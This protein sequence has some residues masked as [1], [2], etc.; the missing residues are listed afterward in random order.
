MILSID[1]WTIGKTV[2]WSAFVKKIISIYSTHPCCGIWLQ[3]SPVHCLFFGLVVDITTLL[4]TM[5]HV[6]PLKR[7]LLQ[8]IN[9][10]SS[11]TKPN[12]KFNWCIT[13]GCKDW[14]WIITTA[15]FEVVYWLIKG[16][17]TLDKLKGVYVFKSSSL[18]L[19]SNFMNVL[20]FKEFQGFLKYQLKLY[21][22]INM[23][24]CFIN[25]TSF[26]SIKVWSINV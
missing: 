20:H 13:I 3:S 14:F 10:Q 25:F 21:Y 1:S 15:E 22:L 2:W 7:F 4:I 5:L 24:C 8:R 11:F 18:M 12:F 9:L 26:Y 23:R 6:I 16:I 17:N 19:F